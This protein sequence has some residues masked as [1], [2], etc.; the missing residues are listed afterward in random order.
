ML[1]LFQFNSLN[2]LW[3]IKLVFL[4]LLVGGKHAELFELLEIP[5]VN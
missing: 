3:M 2:L 4:L 5:L 1:F